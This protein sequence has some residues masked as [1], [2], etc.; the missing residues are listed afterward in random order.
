MQKMR[1][2]CVRWITKM[3]KI[4]GFVTVD[5]AEEIAHDRSALRRFC[6]GAG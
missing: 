6:G 3:R 5:Q 2:D 4:L 1:V